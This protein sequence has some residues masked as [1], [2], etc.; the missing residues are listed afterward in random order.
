MIFGDSGEEL[1]EGSVMLESTV[2]TVVVGDGSVDSDLVVAEE[3]RRTWEV[4]SALW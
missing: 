1:G 4:E 3:P 2:E